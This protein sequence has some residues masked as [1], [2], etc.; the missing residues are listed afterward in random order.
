M[1]AH[2]SFDAA[3]KEAE[4]KKLTD[5]TL[6]SFNGAVQSQ[7]F[8]AFYESTAKL[9]QKET[10][11]DK[12]KAAFKS[13]I[14]KKIFDIETGLSQKRGIIVKEKHKPYG[15]AFKIPN[16]NFRNFPLSE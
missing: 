12:L 3:T 4:L 10:S 7:D 13:F 15:L 16:G 9:W 11:P 8:T 5:A 2:L 14:D 6:L 1:R